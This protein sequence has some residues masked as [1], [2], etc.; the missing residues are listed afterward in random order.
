[1]AVFLDQ[2]LAYKGL[3]V[4]AWLLLFFSAERVRSAARFLS[5]GITARLGRNAG[6]ALA[7]GLLSMA[8]VLPITLWATEVALDWRPSW[9]SSWPGL[10]LDLLILDG[11]IYWWHRL[12]HKV[13]F[14]W[15]FHQVHHLDE[16][17]DSTSAFRFHF[18]EVA[19]S[20]LFRAGFV[21]LLGLPFTSILL[22]ETL[23]L[24]AAIFH[25]SNL[26]LPRGL[27]LALSWLIVTPSI[28]W[29]HHHALRADTDSNYASF[30]S[31]W[32][33][34]FGSRSPNPRRLDMKIGLEGDR[35]RGL[36]ELA[37]LPFTRK[38]ED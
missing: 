11:L 35:D 29:V 13:P 12:N 38:A 28:H 27:E 32:D 21:I 6:L 23:L 5:P 36:L 3:C 10:L 4:V 16:F 20:A 26:R 31:L 30:L 24:F 22:F 18:G 1:M 8:F 19:L 33:R 37:H 17:L 34:L 2:L 14:L 15:R 7:N 9:W 25:H